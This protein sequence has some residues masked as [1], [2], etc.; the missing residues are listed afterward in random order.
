[1]FSNQQ[2][3]PQLDACVMNITILLNLVIVSTGDHL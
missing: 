1:M 3:H 2:K